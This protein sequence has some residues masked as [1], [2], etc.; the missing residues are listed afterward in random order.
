[1][2]LKSRSLTLLSEMVNNQRGVFFAS[3]LEREERKTKEGKPYFRALFSDASRQVN[4]VLWE[5]SPLFAECRDMWKIGALYK[6]DASYSI[7]KYGPQIQIFRI[8]EAQEKDFEEGIPPRFGLPS[9]A[10]N[11]DI[12][13]DKIVSLAKEK[14]TKG[15]PLQRLVL[16]IYKEHREQ[17]LSVSSSRTGHHAYPGGL[18]E[19]TLSVAQIAV[20][21]AEHFSRAYPQTAPTLSTDLVAVGAILHEIGKIEEMDPASRIPVHTVAGDLIGYPILGRDIV[22]RYAPDAELSTDELLRLE[23]ILLTHPR[24]NDWGAVRPPASLEALIVHQA[25]YADSIFA[26]AARVLGADS[27]TAPF[28]SSAGPF[29]IPWLNPPREASEPPRTE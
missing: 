28:T 8:R 4:A 13:Y 23:H 5:D 6:L 3:L 12:L 16:R 10:T 26:D 11:P 17:L 2:V 9:A 29:G 21:L 15:A 24:F 27:G 25:D 20:S 19:H 22:R 7:T 14:I 1:M 18:L